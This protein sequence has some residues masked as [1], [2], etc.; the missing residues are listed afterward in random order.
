MSMILSGLEA[1]DGIDFLSLF[2]ADTTRAAIVVTFLAL[3]E[4]IRIR[5]VWIQQDDHF[6]PIRIFKSKA[7]TI[8]QQEEEINGGSGS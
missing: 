5:L 7:E 1:A 3:L 8:S 4:L 2:E 6:G